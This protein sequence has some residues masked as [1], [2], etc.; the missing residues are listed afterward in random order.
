MSLESSPPGPMRIFA[1]R[2]QLAPFY[3]SLILTLLTRAS[4]AKFSVSPPRHAL[5]VL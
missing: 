4:E 5:S 1:I 2:S 3:D